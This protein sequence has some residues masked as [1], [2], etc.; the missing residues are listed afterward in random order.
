M[1]NATLV[2]ATLFAIVLVGC[3]RECTTFDFSRPQYAGSPHGYVPQGTQI[4]SPNKHYLA[5]VGGLGISIYIP[6][7]NG[8]MLKVWFLPV[9]GDTKGVA[10]DPESKRVAVMKHYGDGGARSV[11]SGYRVFRILPGCSASIGGYYHGISWPVQDT[12]RFH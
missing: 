6:R 8:N 7:A 11:A 1:K 10:W 4:M 9:G 5:I 2:I 12:I 3:D